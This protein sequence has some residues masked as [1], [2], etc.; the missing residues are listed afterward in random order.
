[1]GHDIHYQPQ[2]LSLPNFWLPYAIKITK[3]K[4]L[5]TSV[6]DGYNVTGPVSSI[7]FCFFFGGGEVLKRWLGGGF[8]YFLCLSLFGEDFQFD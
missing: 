6:L 1:M 7:F 8:Q 3:V 2:L 5:A 4:P